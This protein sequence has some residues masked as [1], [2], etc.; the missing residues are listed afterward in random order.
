[1][2]LSIVPEMTEDIVKDCGPNKKL[3]DYKMFNDIECHPFIATHNWE[4]V[5]VVIDKGIMAG[6]LR[7][8][9]SC[10]QN[11]RVI[12][13]KSTSIDFYAISRLIELYPDMAATLRAAYVQKKDVTGILK[14]RGVIIEP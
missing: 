13:P 12:I 6:Y 5:E 3:M 9:I 7:Q 14:E 2:I 4:L 10:T 8:V 11:I 1:M